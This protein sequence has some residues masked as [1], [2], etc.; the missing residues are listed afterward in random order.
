MYASPALN[1][2]RLEI[3]RLQGDGKRMKAILPGARELSPL[4]QGH[5]SGL[6]GLYSMMNAVQLVLYPRRLSGRRQQALF[7]Q[8]VAHL[9]RLRALKRVL[10]VWMHEEHWIGLGQALLNDINC[11][12]GVSLSLER[13]LHGRAGLSHG[14]VIRL[15]KRAIDTCRPVLV[16]LGG[17]L[18]H[19]SV[20][21]GYGQNS[22]RLFDSS[23]LQWINTRAIGLNEDSGFRRWIW[24]EC[25][26]SILPG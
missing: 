23:G 11:A 10:G 13:L 25:V 4:Q 9:A 21:C 17:T 22:L 3:Y 2:T 5:L 14:Q 12:E 8:A 16:C 1:V 6:C 18:D 15:V 7:V 24:S 19:Y 26:Y 20:V